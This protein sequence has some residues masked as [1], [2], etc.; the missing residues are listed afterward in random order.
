MPRLPDAPTGIK[1]ISDDDMTR[2]SSAVPI[3][4]MSNCITCEGS[5]SFRWWND[6]RSEVIDWECNCKAQLIL[7]LAFVSAGIGLQYQRLQWS[8]YHGEQGAMNKVGD[9]LT[10]FDWNDRNGVGLVLHGNVGSGKTLL[11]TLALKMIAAGGTDCYLTT[12]AEMISRFTDGWRD[13]ED[14]R[15]F[16]RRI[17]NAGV[18]VIDDIGRE[19]KTSIN[20]P[21]STFDDVL[22]HRLAS[23]KP[24]IVTTNQTLDQLHTGYGGNVMSLL[25]E[26][27]TSYGFKGT[28]FRPKSKGRVDEE[29]NAG[30]IRP[31]SVS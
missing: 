6:D 28:D 21:E 13:P 15:W 25:T 9:Y 12:F 14:K 23:A 30:I 3:P 11:A 17:K 26:R 31:V 29:R 1:L 4:K 24:T 20:L 18:L 16:H 27:S 19:A 10:N 22:R 8:D 5:L 7:H 2:L